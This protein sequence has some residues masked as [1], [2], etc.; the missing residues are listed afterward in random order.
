MPTLVFVPVR[1]RL[2]R[3]ALTQSRDSIAEALN[4][5]A[6]R[7]LVNSRS[8][9]IEPRRSMATPVAV[10][11]VFSWTGPA[12]STVSTEQRREI[13]TLI[14]R[15]L[16]RAFTTARVDA[17]PVRGTG[18]GTVRRER[19]AEPFARGR[20]HRERRRYVIPAY[21]SPGDDTEVEVRGRDPFQPPTADELR[22]AS[23]EPPP[24]PPDLNEVWKELSDPDQ[25]VS[26]RAGGRIWTLV[27][28]GD[29]RAVRVALAALRA[30]D[31]GPTSILLSAFRQLG[32]DD[33]KRLRALLRSTV[34][35][36]RQR[37]DGRIERHLNAVRLLAKAGDR[38]PGLRTELAML[39][40]VELTSLAVPE[41]KEVLAELEAE[42]R[43]R[44]RI[45]ALVRALAF[46]RRELD[47][48]LTERNPPTIDQLIAALSVSPNVPED[49]DPAVVAAI[50][51]GTESM[52]RLVGIV[53]LAEL[54]DDPDQFLYHFEVDLLAS[55]QWIADT[56]NRIKA[57]DRTLY[58]FRRVYGA[59]Y[60][61]QEEVKVLRDTRAMTLRAV[62]ENPFPTSYW[63]TTVRVVT[64]LSYSGWMER[65]ANAKIAKIEPTNDKMIAALA[66][67]PADLR[68][69]VHDQ[70][71]QRVAQSESE[72]LDIRR[73]LV[74]ARGL[75]GG[76]RLELV[77][78]VEQRV[79]LSWLRVS[80]VQLWSA[81]HATMRDILDHNRGNSEET[82]L[83]WL[84]T[85]GRICGEIEAEYERPDLSRYGQGY[86]QLQSWQWDI[87]S[88]QRGIVAAE[89][90]AAGLK[91]GVA[92]LLTVVTLG[93][94]APESIG[95]IVAVTVGEAVVFAGA[96]TL[97]DVALDKPV[98]LSGF[99]FDVATNIA[100]FGLLKFLNVGLFKIVDAIPAGQTV[101][102]L[103]VIF[104]GNYV[105]TTISGL[106]IQALETKQ[107]PQDVGSFLVLNA[108]LNVIVGVIAGPRIVG[109]LRQMD[110]MR[111]ALAAATALGAEH[112]AWLA[113]MDA[114]AARG[115][116][117][118]AEFKAF[119]QRGEKVFQDLE[120]VFAELQRL[121]EEQ[122]KALRLSKAQLGE[123]RSR[124]RDFASQIAAAR[125][126]GI[127]TTHR[128][129]APDRV[130]G[131]ALV[132]RTGTTFEFNPNTP[133]STP[134][135]L[136]TRLKDAGYSVREEGG[137]IEV[138][139]PGAPGER[140]LLLPARTQ[141]APPTLTSVV[142]TSRNAASG[143]RVIRA[144]NAVPNLELTLETIAARDAEVARAILQGIGRHVEAGDTQALRG[145][146]RFLELGGDPASLG[147]IMGP[148][149][150]YGTVSIP[151]AI[152]T[153]TELTA[154]DV[155]AIDA[156]V[157][158]LGK[159]DRTTDVLTGIA[160]NFSD[161]HGIYGAITE[162]LPATKS[163]L[164]E[165]LRYLSSRDMNRNQ[166]GLGSLL[167][168]RRLVAENPGSAI[169]F[170]VEIQSGG[171]LI[172]VRDIEV[173]LPAG[174]PLGYLSA[175]VKEVVDI[176]VLQ[177]GRSVKQ[178]GR[179]VTIELGSPPPGDRVMK[180][181]RWLIRKPANANAEQ[182]KA[183]HDEIKALLRRAFDENAT[184]RN[185]PR[186]DALLQEYD[187]YFDEMMVFL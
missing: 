122:L 146:A 139:Q 133:G 120:R 39:G 93:I 168:A 56:L 16:S 77:N 87:E 117:T 165:V 4:A 174:D 47:R 179:D 63:L 61:Q 19:P 44:A 115:N 160:I 116:L 40:G 76:E 14:E 154:S 121:S 127:P 137:V 104:G 153:L 157:G 99:A 123:M 75:S 138:V 48:Y 177:I 182:L 85:L 53:M 26:S 178:F 171:Q 59:A 158:M 118:A 147:V 161:R 32:R 23:Q 29:E 186:R 86:N 38:L 22:R 12:V 72:I 36:I 108:L 175:E 132:P 15:E 172:R 50:R 46:I 90:A 10:A 43:G 84:A 94:A 184:L 71:P 134:K 89:K 130:V 98:T 51:G 142:G 126:E 185:H 17:A 100:V 7:A 156:I 66:A 150:N 173:E 163:G 81:A 187:L 52:S 82:R 106:L 96:M 112:A 103:A 129:P 6:T 68:P 20:Y 80:F 148:G 181:I 97:I 140:Y 64:D 69:V 11:P 166:A 111:A 125:Y 143:L 60:D 55:I 67:I 25:T 145:I 31:T 33:P 169:R 167:A 78:T 119:Q 149:R 41:A 54:P 114:V 162:L 91:I 37:F 65:A 164:P 2:D 159:G 70:Y 180:R 105:G 5:A 73:D 144:Q 18:A 58:M 113:E 24:P 79:G 155:K 57:I 27:A 9:V 8:V 102:R 183:A 135:R 141:T 45:A 28:T 49:A 92:L 124:A 109:Q 151:R 152:A 34:A 107:W 83:G 128:L 62:A 3:G 176:T 30:D 131:G 74:A 136:A 88:V 42:R 101:A 13:E 95:A 1:L 170:E 21:D 110:R 35:D